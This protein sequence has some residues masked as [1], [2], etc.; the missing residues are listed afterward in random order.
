[1]DRLTQFARFGVK[2]GLCFTKIYLTL[3]LAGGVLWFLWEDVL[4]IPY[5]IGLLNPINSVLGNLV[6]C[7]I[8]LFFESCELQ[9]QYGDSA[10]LIIFLIIGNSLLFFFLGLL[11]GLTYVFLQGKLLRGT[12]FTSVV[13][14]TRDTIYTF[15]IFII[16]ILVYFFLKIGQ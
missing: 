13:L 16:T 9:Y 12:G 10:V 4:S 8:G 6:D 15:F 7:K 14:L 11:V 3:I 5:F 1:M 2:F